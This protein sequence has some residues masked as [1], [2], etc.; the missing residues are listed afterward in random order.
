MK[1]SPLTKVRTRV[2]FSRMNSKSRRGPGQTGSLTTIETT[3]T[4]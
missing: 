4:I 3:V 1:K 2:V